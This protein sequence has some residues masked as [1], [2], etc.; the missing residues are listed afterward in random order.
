MGSYHINASYASKIASC[1][2]HLA[3]YKWWQRWD[4]LSDTIESGVW[5]DMSDDKGKFGGQLSQTKVPLREKRIK[6]KV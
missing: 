4:N 5:V 6:G 1:S 2:P 3:R